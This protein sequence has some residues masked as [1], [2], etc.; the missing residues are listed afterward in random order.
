MAQLATQKEFSYQQR[1]DVNDLNEGKRTWANERILTSACR[2]QLHDDVLS[3]VITRARDFRR[4]AG[5]PSYNPFP[6]YNL[7]AT[8]YDIC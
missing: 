2:I 7:L 1:H 4:E 5:T 3:K 8:F 6:T